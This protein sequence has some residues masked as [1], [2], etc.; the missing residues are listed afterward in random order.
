LDIEL[1][2]LPKHYDFF[3]PWA[4]MAKAQHANENPADVKASEK[5]AKL[6]DEIKKDNPDDSPEFTHGLYV[7]L[8]RLLFWF[9]AEYTEIFKATPIATPPMIL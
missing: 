4:D 3:L 9:F 6:F 7:F 2:D 5:M 1:K 8:S